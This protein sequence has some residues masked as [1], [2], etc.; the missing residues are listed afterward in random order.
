VPCEA[1]H[2]YDAIYRGTGGPLIIEIE[3]SDGEIQVD[4]GRQLGNYILDQDDPAVF[5]GAIIGNPFRKSPPD[6]RPPDSRPLFSPQ[7]VTLDTRQ[8]WPL[9]YR[10]NLHLRE[11]SSVE[12]RLLTQ[13]F[14]CGSGLAVSG[15]V[16]D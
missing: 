3:G 12:T 7:L 9:I 6:E 14:D 5:N 1:E 13:G 4:K 8:S 15:T 2:P 16:P 10:R 11:G